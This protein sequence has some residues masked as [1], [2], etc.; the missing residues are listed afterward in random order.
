MIS[1]TE[2]DFK[3]Y[4]TPNSSWTSETLRLY[5]KFLTDSW[6]KFP[7]TRRLPLLMKRFE[8]LKTFPKGRILTRCTDEEGSMFEF[9]MF[10]SLDNARMACVAQFGPYLEGV[11]GIAHGGATAALMDQVLGTLAFLSLGRV[12][13]ANLNINY[14]RAIP[15]LSTILF[16]SELQS[17]EDR[18]ATIICKVTSSDGSVLHAEGKGLYCSLPTCRHFCFSNRTTRHIS[19]LLQCGICH[20]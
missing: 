2:V 6:M 9:A 5:N 11:P 15:L 20:V 19:H 18:K 4:G 12:M 1:D 10:Y 16:D 17:K 13:T 8:D 7:S 3:D 14:I